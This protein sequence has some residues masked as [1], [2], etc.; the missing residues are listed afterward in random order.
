MPS[1]RLRQTFRYP[2]SDSDTD[3]DEEHQENLIA[4][5]QAADA[6][7]NTLYRNA[8]LTIP[9]TGAL[10]FLYTLV[11]HTST[12]QQGLLAI[13]GLSSLV[14][15][16]YILHFMPLQAPVRKGK[17]ALYKLDA[18][19]GPVERYMV[20][21]NAGL[22]ALLLLAAGV[23]WRKHQAADGWREALPGIILIMTLFARQQ[24]A[25]LDLEELQ[26]AKYDY[27]GA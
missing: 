10:F 24:L 5:L 1:T 21:L 4:S 2:S 11:L 20:Y 27:K 25:P 26:K 7:Q 15:T 13:L 18:A 9:L 3:L 14:C 12:R 19:K 6:Q 8:F 23:S 17:T 22:A 16:A